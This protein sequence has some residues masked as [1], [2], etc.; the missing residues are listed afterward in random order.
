MHPTKTT[1][2]IELNVTLGYATYRPKENYLCTSSV[3]PIQSCVA[4]LKSLAQVVLKIS[5]AKNC[6]GHV[7]EATPTFRE[8]Y[9][10]AHSAFPTQSSVPNLKYLAQVVLTTSKQRRR[11]QTT[12]R[13]NTVRRNTVPIARPLVR[14]AKSIF[15]LLFHCHSSI[16]FSLTSLVKQHLLLRSFPSRRK[17]ESP[18][19]SRIYKRI[20]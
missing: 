8:N 17:S 18:D 11:R 14:S 15:L 13:R 1:F 7:N 3:F 6:R 20:F 9:L 10:Y 5:Y 16:Y 12:D 4:N 2:P 19:I